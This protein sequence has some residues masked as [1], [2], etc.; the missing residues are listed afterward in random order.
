MSW[1][2]RMSSST[3]RYRHPRIGQ[4]KDLDE[5]VAHREARGRGRIVIILISKYHYV[6]EA[7]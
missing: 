7:A 6:R 4:R 5:L 2:S 3:G 1:A